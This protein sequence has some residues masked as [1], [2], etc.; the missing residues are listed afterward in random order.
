MNNNTE[1]IDNESN[2]DKDFKDIKENKNTKYYVVSIF[3]Y[4]L[5]IAL[6]VVFILGIKYKKDIVEKYFSNRNVNSNILG[7]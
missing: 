5:V 1:R 4:I 7:K 6:I 3:L 2:V